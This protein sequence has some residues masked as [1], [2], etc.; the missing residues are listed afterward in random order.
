MQI[1]VLQ[2]VRIDRGSV[3]MS[4]TSV[5]NANLGVHSKLRFTSKLR[6]STVCRATLPASELCDRRA[7]RIRRGG[8]DRLWVGQCQAL[9]QPLDQLIDL[10]P[11]RTNIF[12]G[13]AKI[14]AHRD[15]PLRHL[16][17]DFGL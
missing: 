2:I 5:H 11:Q 15:N 3:L 1:S 17:V 10:P 8:A 4:V 6:G 12:L 14:F 7:E 9:S 16:L 13:D